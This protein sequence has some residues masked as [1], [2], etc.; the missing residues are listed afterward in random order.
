MLY[1]KLV[2]C[3]ENEGGDW[4]SVALQIGDTLTVDIA[5]EHAVGDLNLELLDPSPAVMDSSTSISDDESVSFTAVEEGDHYIHVFG[6]SDTD[7]N[8]YDMMVTN[9]GGT[10]SPCIDFNGHYRSLFGW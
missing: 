10:A 9:S 4:F 8:T 2:L 1:P 3:A 5:F 7:E 6:A